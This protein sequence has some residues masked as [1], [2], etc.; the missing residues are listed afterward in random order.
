MP[1]C[2][3]SQVVY[4]RAVARVHALRGV[5]GWVGSSGGS[6]GV[7]AAPAGIH[8]PVECPLGGWSWGSACGSGA[9]PHTHV[10]TLWRAH[11]G[12]ARDLLP[13]PISLVIP[14]S[15]CPCRTLRVAFMF[16]VGCGGGA[17]RVPLG[18]RCLKP[19]HTYLPRHAG[20]LPF[21][22]LVRWPAPS[23]ARRRRKTYPSRMNGASPS[24]WSLAPPAPQSWP[25]PLP[26]SHPRSAR[27]QT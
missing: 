3:L 20:S 6:G 8:W 27:D 11:G 12:G 17:W 16:G 9:H 25:G 14:P 4:V 10:H 15:L 21:S 7:S 5:V 26:P 24:M 19:V 2:C 23:P 1:R 22:R 13:I 18:G